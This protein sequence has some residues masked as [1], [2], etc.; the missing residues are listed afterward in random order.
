M[1]LQLE[2]CTKSSL[3]LRL[4]LQVCTKSSLCL[5]LQLLSE[6]L[7]GSQASMAVIAVDQPD[8][9]GLVRSLS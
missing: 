5:R 9:D 3:C 1:C 2:V 7:T 4:Q 6:Q 8:S